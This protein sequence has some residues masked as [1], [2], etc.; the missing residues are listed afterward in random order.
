MMQNKEKDNNGKT[1]ET[2]KNIQR[3]IHLNGFFLH[4]ESAEICL[5]IAYKNRIP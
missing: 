5:W 2:V 1:E 4:S 3:N